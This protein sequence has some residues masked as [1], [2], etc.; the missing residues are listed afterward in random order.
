MGKA[1]A[2]KL[3][4][5]LGLKQKGYNLIDGDQPEIMTMSLGGGYT[6][7]CNVKK[8]S[9]EWI[10]SFNDGVETSE[11]PVDSEK[12][13]YTYKKDAEKLIKEYDAALRALFDDGVR[14][15]EEPET[16]VKE[17]ENKPER[18]EI[19]ADKWEVPSPKSRTSD[20]EPVNLPAPVGI[21]GIV[22]PAVTAME[23]LAA[24][25][26]FQELK[27][28]IIEKS[29]IQ[30]IQGKPHIKKSGW[31]KFATFYNLTDEI[32]EEKE[33]PLDKGGYYWK[34][35][36]ICTAPNGRKTEGVGM[37]ASA[38]KSGAR[39]IHDVYTTAHTRAKNRAISDMIAA[40]EIS[41]EEMEA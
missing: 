35:K 20:I 11:Y 26:E 34:I 40:G 29:D 33:I 3:D 9:K 23:A 27:K 25:K 30:M 10:I 4:I 19:G 5:L 32:V 41:A 18:E 15:K 8:P 16:P 28:Y 36:V 38:E 21:N 39:Q 1:E 17:P 6:L 22:R 37:C 31:R 2:M 13:V 24:W 7:I 14:A 12:V